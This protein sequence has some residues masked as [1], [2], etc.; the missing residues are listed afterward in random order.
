MISRRIEILRL[1]YLFAVI[2]PT[3][4]AIFLNRLDLKKYWN[5]IVAFSFFGISGNI[6]ND[7]FDRKED[8]DLEA[9][10]RTK[11]YKNKELWAI[12]IVSGTLGL[13][14]LVPI[15][16]V[17]PIIGLYSG[18]AFGL[19]II[20]CV[21]KK[22]PILNQV[23]LAMSHIIIPYLIIKTI[24][25]LIHPLLSLGEFF[26]LIALLFFAVS[27]Q[28]VHE[29]I[30]GDAISRF[31]LKTQQ[32]VVIV[33]ALFSIIF[34]FFAIILLQNYILIGLVLIPVGTIYS[35]RHPKKSRKSIK[36]TGIIMGNLVMVFLIVLILYY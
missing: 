6:I 36:D 17:F 14:L 31:S 7:I 30:D 5:L 33:S 3:L 35:F 11:G 2:V 23:L 20:Y 4:M 19:V 21:K 27:G 24:A 8:T 1:D 12:A 13:T 16:F 29:I 32:K 25:D 34:G 9:Q 15:I 26:F 22:I 10:D 18:L 28:T